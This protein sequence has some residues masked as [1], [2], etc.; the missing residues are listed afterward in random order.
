VKSWGDIEKEL[1]R[2]REQRRLAQRNDNWT[3]FDRSEA[4]IDCLEWVLDQEEEEKSD[5]N[6]S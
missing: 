3:I 4:W 5:E 6:Q 1:D 2:Q